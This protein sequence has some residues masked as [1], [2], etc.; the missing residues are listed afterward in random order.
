MAIRELEDVSTQS[1]SGSP[2]SENVLVWAVWK[3]IRSGL[4]DHDDLVHE[5][6]VR[7]SRLPIFQVAP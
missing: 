2:T 7:L 6:R 3:R 4:T 1:Q 5:A